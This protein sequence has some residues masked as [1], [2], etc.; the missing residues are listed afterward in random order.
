MEEV[1]LFL[2]KQSAV[3]VALGVANW[4]QWKEKKELKEEALN[5]RKAASKALK[6]ANE[7]HAAEKEKLYEYIRQSDLSNRDAVN[8]IALALEA[9]KIYIKEDQKNE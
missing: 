3:V 8:N 6:E 9:I 4:A 1:L 7:A 5:D 2:L